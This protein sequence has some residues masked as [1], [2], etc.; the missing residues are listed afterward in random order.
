[1]TFAEIPGHQAI[2]SVLFNAAESD[3][4]PHAILFSGRQGSAGLAL[5]LGFATVVNCTER[6]ENDA[7]GTCPS[8][9]KMARLT[10]PDLTMVVP[11]VRPESVKASD[12]YDSSAYNAEIRAFFSEPAHVYA[13]LLQWRDALKTENKQLLIPV[14]ETRALAE[15][16]AYSAFEGLYKVVVIWLPETMNTQASNAFLKLLEEPPKRTLFLLVSQDNDSL[17]PTILSRTQIISIPSFQD[18][19]VAQW[20]IEN[21]ADVSEAK[22]AAYLADGNLYE[23]TTLLG[24]DATALFAFFSQWMRDCYGHKYAAMLDHVDNFVK[25]GGRE[26]QKKMLLYACHMI[27]QAMLIHQNATEIVRL[28]TN[29]LDFINKFSPFIG[30]ENGAWMYKVLSEAHD[31]I[32]RNASPKMVFLDTSI[33]IASAFV[34]AKAS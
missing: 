29:E 5:A 10:H 15:K 8:C 20:L 28:P 14:S 34:K 23:A 26:P 17:L 4:I 32:E 33:F 18:Y 24:I 30:I 13:G 7:C 1:M 9:H 22:Q 21:E 2:K 31:H 27:R 11:T 3:Q 16:V 6:T 19:E 12:A 25:L